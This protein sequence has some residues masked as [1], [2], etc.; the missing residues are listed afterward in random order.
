MRNTATKSNENNARESFN[1]IEQLERGE[2]PKIIEK[3]KKVVS[4]FRDIELNTDDY[5]DSSG[6]SSK[7]TI[8]TDFFRLKENSDGWNKDNDIKWL[9]ALEKS[10]VNAARNA[11]E[12][13]LTKIPEQIQAG[14]YWW[15]KDQIEKKNLLF[16]Q[17]SGG[18]VNTDKME[19]VPSL[20]DFEKAPVIIGGDVEA[21]YPSMAHIETSKVMYEAI[22]DTKVDFENIDYGY[23]NVYLLL[24]L[25][26]KVMRKHGLSEIP[27]RKNDKSKAR[28]L[29][30]KSNRSIS[31]WV[32][33]REK[34]TVIDKRIM[35]ALTVQ[36]ATLVMMDSSCYTF[37]GEIFSQQSG[38]GI[39]LRGSACSAKILMG[40]WDQGWCKIQQKL[41]LVV[42]LIFRYIDDIRVYMAPIRE[43]WSWSQSGWK[44]DPNFSDGLS[45]E[46][47][48]KREI[49]KSF[50]DVMK[51]LRFTAES[52]EDFENKYLPTLDVQLKVLRDGKITF[53]H[54]S[55]PMIN[56][57][58][59][60]KGTALSKNTVFSSLRQD[61]VRRLLNT[62]EEEGKTTKLGIIE[63]FIQLLRNSGHQYAF[64]KS[65]ILQ[66]VT[67]YD[68]MVA[69]S[70]KNTTDESFQPL[71]RA[72]SFKEESRKILKYIN[73]SL[74][75][76]KEDLGDPFRQR[77]KKFIKVKGSVNIKKQNGRKVSAEKDDRV[78]TTTLFVPSSDNG[79]LLKLLEGVEREIKEETPWTVKLVEKS[80][81]PLKNLLLPKFPLEDGCILG[82][83]CG[84]C[85]NNGINCRRKSVVYIAECRKCKK[86][87][88]ETDDLNEEAK[89][90]YIG[91]TAR[92]FRKR[93]EE[94]MTLLRNLD[95]KSFQ[96]AHWA[97]EHDDDLECPEFT[98]KVL[99][100]F[101]DALTRQITEAIYIMENGSLNKRNEFRMNEICRMGSKFSEK[102]SEKQRNDRIE[103]RIREESKIIEFIE[104]VKKRSMHNS[105][106]VDQALDTCTNGIHFNYRDTR[107][108]RG[109]DKATEAGVKKKRRMNSSTP[110]PWRQP[111][112]ESPE[113]VFGITPIR[114]RNDSPDQVNPEIYT[115]RDSDIKSP[116]D[117]GRTNMSNELRGSIITPRKAETSVENDQSLAKETLMLE[118]SS[119]RT[120]CEVRSLI[121]E[122][123]VGELEEN[124]YFS[125]Y[126]REKTRSL[127][128]L[129]DDIDLNQL[130][131]WSGSSLR[132]KE[133]GNL[134]NV[135]D[136][137]INIGM[138]A[139]KLLLA[140]PATPGT[141]GPSKRSLSPNRTT[142]RGRPR[143]FSSSQMARQ[144]VKLNLVTVIPDEL[145]GLNK[146]KGPLPE[147]KESFLP[148]PR[149]IETELEGE[150]T[151]PDKAAGES[152]HRNASGADSQ[153]TQHSVTPRSTQ[154]M[155]IL[156]RQALS[157]PRRKYK[158]NRG[159]KDVMNMINQP[160][161]SQLLSP[162]NKP[163]TKLQ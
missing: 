144:E 102:D 115:D 45:D 33:K 127:D 135:M 10:K 64:I 103:S 66:A 3:K 80:G 116:V 132:E 104:K 106:V 133:V 145:V 42:H 98:F 62:S 151:M 160:K 28:S 134:G 119:A 39:G 147:E 16:D 19:K 24:S 91:E 77:W 142:P 138:A 158:A 41:G 155:N 125:T 4:S 38:S 92:V 140:E 163:P 22:M 69:R 88:K 53:K 95:P 121:I 154:G 78:I 143:K 87:L 109:G 152:Y 161:I 59:L 157:T 43:G 6:S 70:K 118:K 71:Y 76:T 122:S 105:R 25:G 90:V 57:I 81:I 29:H 113:R 73:Y 46:E 94:H 75:Y 79:T 7:Q 15:K 44:F 11:G 128:N 5:E 139:D 1:F 14:L 86:K 130:D 156:L 111:P 37:G 68:Y 32:T 97:M 123:G 83:E 18:I 107:S 49:S 89:S 101:R 99:G 50:N 27:E 136:S 129:L 60:Q 82:Q 112:A 141:P 12:D 40:Y 35:L 36:T 114:G 148:K 100:Q 55:K 54:F 9:E 13:S 153:M 162:K 2:N 47:R 124:W 131:D 93:V 85:E 63:D 120:G 8:L 48:T 65:I 126:P 56:N 23:M 110:G 51:F 26:E 150:Q 58:V 117:G 146:G 34:L 84:A 31:N 21:L 67:K 72:R 61:L 17:V 137:S 108:K 74:W 20:Q 52:A 30:S 96:L 149:F 159:K